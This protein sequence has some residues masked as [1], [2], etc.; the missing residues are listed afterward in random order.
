MKSLKLLL[1]SSVVALLCGCGGA[2]STSS[3]V[4]IA[5]NT[6]SRIGYFVD[7][8]GNSYLVRNLIG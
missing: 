7:S 1:L 5:V 3:K 4:I 6:K 2:T 8:E